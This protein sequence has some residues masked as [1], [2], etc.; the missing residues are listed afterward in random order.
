MVQPHRLFYKGNECDFI[1]F[2]EDDDLLK[3]YKDNDTTIPLIDI[4]SIYK[5]FTNRQGGVE[6]VLDEA[7]K[8]ELQSEFGTKNA[9][10]IIKKIVN[11]G[12]DK[13]GLSVH[14]GHNAHNDSMGPSTIT[15]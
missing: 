8:Q 7:S 3:K 15:N 10:E 5:I 11:E 9:D 2:V 4:L 14:S 6:G 12:V 1:I 13:L